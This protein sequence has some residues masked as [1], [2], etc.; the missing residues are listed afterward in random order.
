MEEER[1]REKQ[2][3]IKKGELKRSMA[4]EG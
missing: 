2:D 1:V 3:K 4:W